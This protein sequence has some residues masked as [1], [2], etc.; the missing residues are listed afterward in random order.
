MLTMSRKM[1]LS[2]MRVLLAVYRTFAERICG[3]STQAGV[4]VTPR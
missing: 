2:R 1:S 3:V 4:E